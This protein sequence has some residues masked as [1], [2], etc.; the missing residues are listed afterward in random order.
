MYK[1]FVDDSR[2]VDDINAAYRGKTMAEI[3]ELEDARKEAIRDE[4]DMKH[5][6]FLNMGRE[7]MLTVRKLIEYLQKQDPDACILAY[8]QNSFAYIEQFPSLPSPD[9]CTV[10]EDKA[11]LKEDLENWYRGSPGSDMKIKK[12]I[13]MTY[14]YAK[15]SDVIIK[16]S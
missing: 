11:R 4:V 5:E 7:K 14:R 6:Q 1:F 2:T 16:F 15:D 12:E 10:A 13:E 8:E 3:S 9:I